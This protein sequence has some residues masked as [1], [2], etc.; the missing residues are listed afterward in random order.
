MKT[1]VLTA[2]I[3]ALMVGF[4]I[5]S[6]AGLAPDADGDG[7]PDVLD[8]CDQVANAGV[9]TGGN[10]DTNQDGFGNMCDADLDQTGVVNVK[11]LGVWRAQNAL[12]AGGNLAADMDCSG[13]INVKDLGRWR[14]INADPSLFSSGLSCAGTIP[15]S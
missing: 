11:D 9:G 14:S 7:I 10:C 15:C 5:A 2:M 12:G 3:F 4:P 13:V 8:N 1:G 6:M